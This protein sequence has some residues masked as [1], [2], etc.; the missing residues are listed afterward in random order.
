MFSPRLWPWS[1]PVVLAELISHKFL[2]L[3]LPLFMIGALVTNAL[4]VMRDSEQVLLMLTLAAQLGIYAIAGIGFLARRRGRHLRI[5]S[6]AHYIVSSN[7]AAL[8]G[9]VRY[10]RGRQTVLWEKAARS[11]PLDA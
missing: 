8:S 2:R 3:L 11:R 1:R 7:V 6:I 10:L 4:V 5:P 9:L